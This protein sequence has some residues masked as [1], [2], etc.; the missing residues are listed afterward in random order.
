MTILSN[1]IKHNK[2]S[3]KV[4]LDDTYFKKSEKGLKTKNT[5][6]M[7]SKQKLRGISHNLICYTTAVGSNGAVVSEFNEYGKNTIEKMNMVFSSGFEPQSTIYSD[8][9][10]AYREFAK[11]N[12][13]NLVQ[14]NS[15]VVKKQ[16]KLK[17]V[18]SLHAMLK[19][20][21]RRTRG[22]SNKYLDKYVQ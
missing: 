5:T 22:V 8:E 12:N 14:V 17:H 6:E 7:I 15:K 21:I 3:G 18:N 13:I 4:E 19:N 2:L 20:M 9:E 10:L 1:V 11:H 16:N